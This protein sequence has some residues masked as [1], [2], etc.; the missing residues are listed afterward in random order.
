MTFA[1]SSWFWAL[2]LLP[3]LTM[4]FFRNESRR[5][6]LLR[7]LVAARLQD[8]LAGT[9][10]IGRRR[11]RFALLLLA[12][13]CVIASLAR[14]RFGYTW[15]ESK[16]KGRDVLLAVDCSRSMLAT[17]LAPSRLGR[18]KLVA[19]DLIGQLQGDR[20]GLIAFAGTSF[21]QAPLTADHSAVLNALAELDTEIIPRGGTDIASAI[22]EASAA[23]GKGES[24]NRALIIFTDGEELDADGVAAAELQKDNIKIFTVGLGSTDGSLIPVP[25]RNGGTE[26]VKD[27]NGNIVKSKLDEDRLRKIAEVTG[28]FYLHLV[29]GPPE[30]QQIVHAGLG[31]MKEQEY[32]S[33]MSRRPIERYQWPLSTG[34]VLLVIS[35]LIHERKRAIR[36]G[37]SGAALAAALLLGGFLSPAAQ[38]KNSGV[39]AYDRQ[40]Y[41]GAMDEF[42]R[43]IQRRGSLEALQFD[44]GTA[45]YKAGDYGKAPDAFGKAVTSTDPG[46]HAAA[47][48]NI[49]NTLFQRGAAASEKDAKKREW[50]DAIQHYEQALQVQPRHK[51]AEYN[52]DAVKAMLAALDNPP[53]DQQQQQQQQQQNK[54][55]KKNQ[56][57]QQQQQQQSQSGK[58]DKDQQSQ[59]KNQQ[60][61]QQSQKDQDSQGQQSQENQQNA[62]GNKDQQNKDQQGKGEQSKDQQGKSEDKDK[63]KDQSGQENKPGK[64]DEKPE[65]QNDPSGKSANAS[66]MKQGQK[67]D[68][69][70]PSPDQPDKKLAGE[71]QAQGNPPQNDPQQE[72]AAEAEA[73]KEGKMTAAQAR[74]L[75][76]SLKG[77]DEHVQL[78]KRDDRRSR[79]FR[80]W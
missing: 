73:G 21:L 11:L 42:G 2:L 12:L 61:Q 80:D 51:D 79:P 13:G 3:V 5:E 58:Q 25:G 26:F 52:R 69:P 68:Q 74:A 24:D 48:Y 36:R 45:A 41:Q 47:E 50:K 40:D 29:S 56:D 31:Q 70:E 39:E 75:L 20:V 4:L 59:D 33:H 67:Q 9:V 22:R 62:Q 37:G 19:Q 66:P 43:Q 14:P 78:L 8:R 60:Q 30:M 44:L 38:A 34:L 46:L 71:I 6:A 63:G 35:A 76:E 49:G 57:Q 65:G 64:G 72:A 17:D 1:Q 53:P 23:F 55:D 32:E 54:D 28:G 18:A 16:H 77:E 27:E 10:S 15:E 7:K